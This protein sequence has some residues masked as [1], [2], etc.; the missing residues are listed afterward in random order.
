M[1]DDPMTERVD[2]GFREVPPAEKTRLVGRVFESVAGRYDLMNDLMSASLHRLWKR[3][4]VATLGLEPGMRALDLAAG[5]GDVAALVAGRL[6]A[7]GSVAATDINRAM[8]SRGRDRL[9]D[10]NLAGQA[11]FTQADAEALPFPD[12][13]FHRV[14]MAFG[15]RNVTRKERVLTEAFR[16]LRPGGSF[17]VLEFSKIRSR[18]FAPAYDLYSF[19]VLPALGAVVAG[20]AESYRYLAESI[21]RHPDQETLESMFRQAGF[22]R[23][24]C[25]NLN[26][27]VVAIHTGWR[28]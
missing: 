28:L 2:F 25:R 19:K 8:L 26:A 21:R 5:T 1:S 12:R 9:I 18:L 13:H 24:T 17:S 4:F 20:D 10:D 22:E 7:E 15:L 23:V 27:G 11:S 16:V 3:Y 6:G 14:T